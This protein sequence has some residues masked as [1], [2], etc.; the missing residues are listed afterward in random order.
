MHRRLLVRSSVA[1]LVGVLL[2]CLGLTAAAPPAALAATVS[3]SL[4]A[5]ATNLAG[6]FVPGFTSR[7]YDSRRT[8]SALLSGQAV[9]LV[10]A[11]TSAVPVGA[12]GAVALTAT[13]TGASSSTYL[14]IYPTGQPRPGTSVVNVQRGETRTGHLM[15]PLGAGGAVTVMVVGSSAHV[16]VDVNGWYTRGTVPVPGALQPVVPVRLLDTRRDDSRGRLPLANGETVRTFVLGRGGLPDSGVSTVAVTLT[17]PFPAHPAHLLAWSGTGL[18]PLASALNAAPGTIVSNLA[19]VPVADDGTIAVESFGGPA[20]LVVDLVGW[21]GAGSGPGAL[22]AVNPARLLDTRSGAAWANGATTAMGVLGRSG[23][24]AEGVSAVVLNLTTTGSTAAGSLTVH[25][26]DVPAPAAPAVT[27]A[28]GGVRATLTTVPVG[29]DGRIEL[30]NDGGPTHVV[31]DVQGY[32]AA[33]QV[34]ASTPLTA[35]DAASFAGG[36]PTSADGQ[37]AARV[38][39]AADSYALRVWW[40]RVAP[41]LLRQLGGSSSS[42]DPQRRLA[43]VALGLATALRT[44]VYD[45][46]ATGVSEQQARAIAV[47]LVDAVAATHLSNR[48][49][50]WGTVGQGAL[51]SSLAGRAGWLLWGDLPAATRARVSRMVELEADTAMAV[52]PSYLRDA[53]GTVVRSGN[54]AAEEDSW[55]SLPLQLATATMRVH[56]HWASWRHAEVQLLL[57]SWARPQDV[58][59]PTVVN[60]HPVSDW[61]DGSNVEPDGTV[62]NH[63]RV[64][65]DYSTNIYQNVDA[66]LVDALAGTATPAAALRGLGPVR[67]ALSS[68]DFDPALYLAPG[69]PI[70]QDGPTPVYYPQGCDWGTGQALPFA[71]VDAESSA[72]G[73]G[74]ATSDADEDRHLAAQ[75]ALQARATDGRTFATDAEYRYAGREEHTAQLASQLLLTVVV[76]DRHLAHFTDADYWHPAAGST[77]ATAASRIAPPVDESALLRR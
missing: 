6:V 14:S 69:G 61:V 48:V 73:F 31:I 44:G 77:T 5:P 4:V 33:E 39:L 32:Y 30:R 9:T 26:I 38:L 17:V 74:T 50:G 63:N 8:G 59:D 60:G 23:V 58:D 18:A 11:G 21:A 62:I 66:V 37:E 53:T 27:Y 68:V 56:P 28:A 7:L 55:V 71:L 36:S 65:P 67:A 49:G 29:R 24:P 25:A 42:A 75:L 12:A 54:T 1:V 47:T 16:Q 34:P 35:P 52:R 43:M 72:F 76:R 40:P 15:V 20:P 22:T 10:L 3:P 2:A 13:L 41:D 57:A 46:S 51:W 64:A 19:V 70:Y 45:A